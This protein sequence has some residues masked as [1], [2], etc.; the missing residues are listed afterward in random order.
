VTVEQRPEIEALLAEKRVFPP[1]PDFA[2]KANVQAAIYEEAE[3]DF[4]GFWARIARE[5]ISWSKP[6]EKILE[7]DL[8]FAKWFTGGELNVA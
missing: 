6:F 1:H 5:R 4:E 2:A 8:P 7:W 3:A